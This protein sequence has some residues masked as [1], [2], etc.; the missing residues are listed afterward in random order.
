[1]K[2]LLALALVFVLTMSLLPIAMA[3]ESVADIIAQAQTMTLDELF[4]KAIEESNGKRFDA[5]GNSSRGKSVLPLFIEEL[6][7]IDAS[8]TLEFSWQQ[9]KNNNIFAQLDADV[10]SANHEISMTLIQDG[11][12]IQSKMLDTGVLLNFVPKAWSEAVAWPRTP[13]RIPW[14]CRP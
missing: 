8:Y 2:K 9:P 4:H 11:N 7:K 6:Q 13:M 3:D 1:M 12:Q 14:P 5:V 10:N